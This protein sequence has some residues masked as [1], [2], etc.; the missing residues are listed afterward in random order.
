MN[1]KSLYAWWWRNRDA[2]EAESN[3]LFAPGKES[4]GLIGLVNRVAGIESCLPR[5]F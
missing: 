4:Y 3:F 1:L 2:E 5:I